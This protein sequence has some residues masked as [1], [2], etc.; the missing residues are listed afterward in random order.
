[1]LTRL[2]NT[3]AADR[4]RVAYEEAGLIAEEDVAQNQAIGRAWCRV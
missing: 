3:A 1:M 2:R 4:V